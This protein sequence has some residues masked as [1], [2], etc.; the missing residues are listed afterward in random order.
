MFTLIPLFVTCEAEHAITETPLG[1]PYEELVVEL[2]YS[3]LELF[4]HVSL[5]SLGLIP[6]FIFQHPL[7]PLS[8]IFL[9][10]FITM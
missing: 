10:T 6:I 8:V 9:G 1:Q 4:Q 3:C 2:S 7:I 5:D